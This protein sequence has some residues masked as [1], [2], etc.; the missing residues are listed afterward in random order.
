MLE[1]ITRIVTWILMPPFSKLRNRKE[2][3][4]LIFCMM[5]LKYCRTCG[6]IGRSNLKGKEAVNMRHFDIRIRVRLLSEAIWDSGEQAANHVHTQALS[7]TNGFVYYH[8]KTFKG[9]L[10][11]QAIWLYRLYKEAG[12]KE[13]AAQFIEAVADLFGWGKEEEKTYQIENVK[14]RTGIMRL[15]HLELPDAVKKYLLGLLQEDIDS[16]GPHFYHFSPQ[17]LL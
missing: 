7:D 1:N 15:G 8:A 3:R 13:T 2:R 12:E 11:K 14:W 4:L 16:E 5:F 10:K 6:N 17:D 9:Q